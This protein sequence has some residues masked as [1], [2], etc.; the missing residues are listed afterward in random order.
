MNQ[1]LFLCVGIGSMGVALLFSSIACT[2]SVAGSPSGDPPSSQ[3][4]I[5]GGFE[6]NVVKTGDTMAATVADATGSPV[7]DYEGPFT[8]NDLPVVK[9]TLANGSTGYHVFPEPATPSS[10][11]FATAAYYDYIGTSSAASG[12]SSYD[13]QGCD[14][15]SASTSCTSVG[16]CCD[17]HDACYAQNNCAANSWLTGALGEL[18]SK[19]A[20]CNAAVVGCFAGGG[21]GPAACCD[22]GTC[23][24]PWGKPGEDGQCICQGKPN[25]CKSSACTG[26]DAGT[27][28][29]S[30]GGSGSDG[31]GG[32]TCDNSAHSAPT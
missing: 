13:L 4:S 10:D 14:G 2:T 24:Q 3:S 20:A 26:S 22:T 1:A 9:Y 8:M 11:Y 32:T 17:T 12:E 16:S 23:K 18:V 28:S 19:C 31:G 5:I 7:Y 25:S 21:S 6:V 30:G 29:G 15:F 27:D